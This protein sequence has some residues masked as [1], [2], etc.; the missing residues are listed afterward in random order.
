MY[1][2][3]HEI[4]YFVSDNDPFGEPNVIR[5][6]FQVSIVFIQFLPTLRVYR[7]LAIFEYLG[8]GE[9]ATCVIR[10]T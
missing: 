3:F 9:R 2:I 4:H 10:I 1:L 5:K 7:A 8:I 6:Q